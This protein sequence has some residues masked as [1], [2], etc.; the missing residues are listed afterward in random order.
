MSR[1]ILPHP[2]SR[3][4][5]KL[6]TPLPDDYGELAMR[7]DIAIRELA[8]PYPR[9]AQMYEMLIADSR[10]DAHWNL[11]NYTTVGKL[12]YN[13]HG[14]IHARVTA[15]YAMQ[16]MQLLLQADV[17]MDVVK[18]GAGDADDACLVV[19]AGVMLHDIGNAT[20]RVGH[21]LM[22]VILAQPILA[23]LLAELYDDIEQRTLIGDFILSAIQCHDM[24]PP[25]LFMEGG[26]VAVADGCDMTKGRARMPFDLG[27]LDIHAVSALAIEEVNIRP[28]NGSGMPVEIEV[29]MSNSA[30]IFQVEET[31]IKKIN[32]TPLRHYVMVHVTSINPEQHFEKRILSN[33][34][35][36]NGRLKPV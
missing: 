19:L 7:A 15:S 18:S 10:V 17:P 8:T 35:L 4:G 23:D 2:A 6:N 25:P 20:H 28:S 21:E 5:A 1:I 3:D 13:D 31:L 33:A 24:N 32:A 29:R 27:K 36:E 22:S 30:G 12:N 34:M 9:T 16:I 11:S 14:P 26:V